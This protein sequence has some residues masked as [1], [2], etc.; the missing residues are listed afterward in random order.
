VGVG[1]RCQGEYLD[2]RGDEII[3]WRNLP[4]EGF[5]NL[6]SSPNIIRMSKSRMRW[7]GHVARMRE[8]SVDGFGGN[9]EGERPLTKPRCRRE[10]IKIYLR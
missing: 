1:E 6:C 3:G 2:P 7:A 10:N 9:P 5:C 4:N 8:K